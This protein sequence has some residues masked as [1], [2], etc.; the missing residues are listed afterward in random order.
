MSNELSLLDWIMDARAQAVTRSVESV[1]LSDAQVAFHNLMTDRIR[2]LTMELAA[3]APN[4]EIDVGRGI[5][6]IDFLHQAH[7]TFSHALVLAAMAKK[8]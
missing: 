6:A 2:A 4:G 5:A 8:K 7:A 1:Q 3:A